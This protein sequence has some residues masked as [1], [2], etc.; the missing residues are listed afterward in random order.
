MFSNFTLTDVLK[1]Y[2]TGRIEELNGVI[3]NAIKLNVHIKYFDWFWTAWPT[4]KFQNA[5]F[6]SVGP[7]KTDDFPTSL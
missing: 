4:I 7:F 2:V 5:W 1:M 3:G 6:L